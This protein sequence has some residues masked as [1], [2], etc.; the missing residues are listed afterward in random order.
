MVA[1]LISTLVVAL[2]LQGTLIE[3]RLGLRTGSPV[4]AIALLRRLAPGSLDQA[5]ALAVTARLG[6]GEEQR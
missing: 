3:M 4:F 6:S 5:T 2:V 1:I